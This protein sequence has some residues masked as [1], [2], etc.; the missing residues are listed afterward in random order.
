MTK[1]EQKEIER[2]MVRFIRLAWL[3]V[4]D[5][6]EIAQIIKRAE[7]RLKSVTLAD[8]INEFIHELEEVSND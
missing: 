1:L 3:T 8:E 5:Y 4:D 2:K 7:E 6:K